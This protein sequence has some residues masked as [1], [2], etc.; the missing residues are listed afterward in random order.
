[1]IAPFQL[2]IYENISSRSVCFSG[3]Y[4]PLFALSFLEAEK[5]MSLQSGLGIGASLKDSA[6]LIIHYNQSYDSGCVI[7]MSPLWGFFRHP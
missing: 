1:L 4:F 3:S 7:S 2:F 5:R 6:S